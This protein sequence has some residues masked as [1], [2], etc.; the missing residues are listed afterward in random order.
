MGVAGKILRERRIPPTLDAQEASWQLNNCARRWSKTRPEAISSTTRCAGSFPAGAGK[1]KA[2]IPASL[3]RRREHS[4]AGE[5]LSEAHFAIYTS[6]QAPPAA[7][8]ASFCSRRRIGGAAPTSSPG[9][10]G[11]SR[12]RPMFPVCV[13]IFHKNTSPKMCKITVDVF[14]CTL[15]DLIVV[16]T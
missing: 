5:R 13:C 10:A 8:C 3:R 7:K 6:D 15:L 4:A 12:V 2:N 16:F 9:G 1:C 14:T 11:I